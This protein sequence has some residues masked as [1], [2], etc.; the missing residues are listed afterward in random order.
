MAIEFV[1]A[2]ESVG[3]AFDEENPWTIDAPADT[4]EDDFLLALILSFPGAFTYLTGG[5]VEAETGDVDGTFD[6]SI[7]TKVAGP[8]E[9]SYTGSASSRANGILSAW[10]GADGLDG[11]LVESAFAGGTSQ[12]APSITPSGPGRVWVAIFT[13]VNDANTIASGPAGFDGQIELSTDP[14]GYTLVA[15]YKLLAT[16]DPTGTASATWTN[17]ASGKNL[18]LLINPVAAAGFLASFASNSNQV[19]Q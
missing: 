7:G 14:A 19:L 13:D 11:A 16:D 1:N 5:L 2:S 12:V 15:Y 10:R 3:P 18:S 4:E 17:S 9:S 8:S 6:Y